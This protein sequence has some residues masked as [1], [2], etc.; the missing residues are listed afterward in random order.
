MGPSKDFL[1]ILLYISN[2]KTFLNE[3]MFFTTDSSIK[4]LLLLQEFG[5]IWMS[6]ERKSIWQSALLMNV[7]YIVFLSGDL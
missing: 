6:I 4:H 7:V 2:S 1:S 5:V 3:T